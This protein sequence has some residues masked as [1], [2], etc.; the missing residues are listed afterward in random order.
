MSIIARTSACLRF[1]DKDAFEVLVPDALTAVLGRP[2]T[3]FVIRGQPRT[4][5]KG[6]VLRTSDGAP[7]L[8]DF[9][10]WHFRVEDREPG[11]LDGQIRELFGALT[12]DL[13]IW[14]DLAVFDPDLFV[15][16]FME[17]A[18]EGLN[19]SVDCLDILASRGV[20][21]DLD[22]YGEAGSLDDLLLPPTDLV[23]RE[24]P[25]PS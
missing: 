7:L 2:P 3:R 9:S 4:T 24:R 21:L 20:R 12:S 22:I 18:N 11:D 23:H 6:T 19:I 8:A 15:G 5:P 10:A 25:R 16:V 17:E 13:S 1:A 14:R